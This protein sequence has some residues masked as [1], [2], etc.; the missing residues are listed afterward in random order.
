M[1]LM[2]ALTVVVAGGSLVYKSM[3]AGEVQETKSRLAE[4]QG[5]C[6]RA[7][8]EMLAVNTKIS[9]RKWQSRLAADSKRWLGILDSALGS[10][11]A[12]V[13]LD[14]IKNSDKESTLAITGRAASFDAVTALISALRCRKGFGEVRLESAKIEANIGVSC[15][16]FVLAVT[17]KDASGGSPASDTSSAGAPAASP[18]AASEPAGGQP[19][20]EAP[21]APSGRVPNVQGST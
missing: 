16:D 20:G 8:R 5:R 3:F 14:S 21:P 15:V 11:P 13:W 19:A 1:G 7:K 17:L 4:A 9:E 6:A 18:P 2:I 10:I 12:D